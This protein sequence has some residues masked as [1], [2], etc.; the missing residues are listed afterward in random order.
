MKLEGTD[1]FPAEIKI[2]RGRRRSVELTLEDGALVA[3][4]PNRM[5]LTD[6]RE[7]LTSLRAQL[8]QTLRRKSVWTLGDLLD[9]AESVAHELLPELQ[10]P[11]FRVEFSARQKKRWGSCTFD[12]QFGHIRITNRLMGHPRWVIRHL[13]LH[14]LIHLVVFNHG[15]R[16]QKLLAR[17]PKLER[18]LGYLE[19]LE[20]AETFGDVTSVGARVGM[21][22]PQNNAAPARNA[23]AGGRR[24]GEL[25]LFS[26]DQQP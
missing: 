18:A 9:E 24:D 19:A 8:W 17:D 2:L 14:E 21:A 12:G 13:L 6:L 20:H 22:E 15:P 1:P 11:P 3:R 10:L 26:Q 16:F 7:V 4:A 23:G 5:N 25:P